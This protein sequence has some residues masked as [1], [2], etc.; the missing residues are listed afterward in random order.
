MTDTLTG[1][2][3]T[4]DEDWWPRIYIG[5]DRVTK[6]LMIMGEADYGEETVQMA[7]A[8]FREDG[9]AGASSVEK[10]IIALRL[11][12]WQLLECRRYGIMPDHQWETVKASRR[13]GVSPLDLR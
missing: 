3:G 4:P 2:R 9:E 7:C 8:F 13:F 6:N 10:S 12:L 5:Y 1:F 11:S